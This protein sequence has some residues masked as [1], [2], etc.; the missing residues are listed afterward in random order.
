MKILI[1]PTQMSFNLTIGDWKPCKGIQKLTGFAKGLSFHRVDY[2]PYWHISNSIVL[3]Y[4]RSENEDTVRLWMYAYLDGKQVSELIGEYKVG[5]KVKPNLE[6]TDTDYYVSVVEPLKS[7]RIKQIKFNK[8]K[9]LPIGWQ[10]YPYAEID[11]TEK[12]SKLEVEIT[13]LKIK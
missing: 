1:N 7:T 5:A 8:R 6:M 2:F 12:R 3:G 11:G 9:T 13:D 10:L 4:N